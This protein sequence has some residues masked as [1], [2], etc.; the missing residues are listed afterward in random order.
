MTNTMSDFEASSE[1]TRFLNNAISFMRKKG[2]ILPSLL[3]LSK[4]KP[5]D[6]EINHPQILSVSSNGDDESWNYSSDKIYE[7][8]IMLRIDKEYR[9]TILDEIAR[10]IAEEFKPDVIGVIS[11][12]L[13]RDSPLV[14]SIQDDPLAIRVIFLNYFLKGNSKPNFILVPYFKNKKE[15][16][17]W[18]DDEYSVTT[19]PCSWNTG[20][21]ETDLLFPYPYDDQR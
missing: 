11:A 17:Q 12:C 18:E 4:G 1:M 3:V 8:G 15:K 21:D 9:D 16:V 13:L 6:I 2:Y 10:S 7:Y 5:L 19:I 20:V 14:P